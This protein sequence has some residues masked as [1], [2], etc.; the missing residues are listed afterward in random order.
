M[1]PAAPI[2]SRRAL[3]GSS[4]DVSL[5]RPQMGIVTPL[6]IVVTS[7][8][9]AP[10]CSPSPPCSLASSVTGTAQDPMRIRVKIGSRSCS[11]TGEGDGHGGAPADPGTLHPDR[12][13]LRLDQRSRDGQA[14]PAPTARASA[15]A[16][17]AVEA[18][19]EVR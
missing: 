17:D 16:V 4:P 3:T 18:L 10:E 19:E 2:G 8:V 13:P 7:L 11:D 12:A 1:V 6:I 5:A 15:R 9:L 14:D